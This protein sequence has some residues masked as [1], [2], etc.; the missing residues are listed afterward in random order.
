MKKILVCIIIV[1]LFN[2]CVTY[3]V[4]DLNYAIKNKTYES[5]SFITDSAPYQSA[6]KVSNFSSTDLKADWIDIKDK[7][8]DL[9]ITNSAN[10]IVIEKFDLIGSVTRG[11]LYQIDETEIAELNNK[12]ETNSIF[13]FRDELG[14]MLTTNFRTELT[15]GAT[16]E[17]LRDKSYV[18]IPYGEDQSTF[19]IR[20]NKKEHQLELTEGDNYF[21][22]SRQINTGNFDPTALSISVGGQK[23]LKLEDKGLAKI[24]IGTFD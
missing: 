3:K 10:A 4:K 19:D 24:W 22:I 20:V 6:I 12:A 15:V 2:S 5:A 1:T 9:A 21:W 8:I 13:I 16:T 18:E 7:L 11:S 23:I 14:S 17:K